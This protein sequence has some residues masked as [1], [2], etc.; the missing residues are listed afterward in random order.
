[1]INMKGKMRAA[2]LY[3]PMDLRVVDVDI[4]EIGPKQV[5]IR[6]KA[7][8]ICGSDVHYYKTGK[9]AFEVKKPLILGHEC[10]GVVAEIGNDVSHLSVGYRVAVEPGFP[11]KTCMYC[12]QGR[13]NLCD[14]IRFYGSPHFNGAFAEYVVADS[15]FVYGLPENIDFDDGVLLEPLSVGIH[16]ARRAGISPGKTVAIFG[17]GPVGLMC[18]Q[19]AKVFGASRVIAFDIVEYL[20][21]AANSLGANVTVNSSREDPLEIIMRE[22]SGIGVDVA[23]EASGVLKVVNTAIESVCKG[24]VVV[25]VGTLPDADIPVNL[26]RV[27]SKEIDYRGMLRYA[28]TYPL[29]INLATRCV[30]KLKPLITHRVRLDEIHR[31]LKIAGEKLDRAIK[32][33][34]IP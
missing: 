24:G 27:V 26:R 16:A 22:T 29:A 3:K 13:Y 28:N 31:G 19:A 23:I 17:A 21:E 20:L 25:Q 18:I 5:L 14:S 11:D 8:G 1:M 9:A 32:V 10:T 2:V 33:I 7:V 34:V 4:P 30:V 6:V 12:K 15:D